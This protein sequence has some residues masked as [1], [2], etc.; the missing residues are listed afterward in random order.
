MLLMSALIGTASSARAQ[1]PIKADSGKFILL[2]QEAEFGTDVFTSDADG[3]SE[4]EIAITQGG[5]NLKVHIS[6]TVQGGKLTRV[7][8]E[9]RPGGKMDLTVEGEKGKL[10]VGEI[11]ANN[12]PRSGTARW[13]A[14]SC[15]SATGRSPRRPGPALRPAGRRCAGTRR[16]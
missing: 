9:A 16:P 6:V 7:V 15:T 10:A 5:V 13:P 8:A 12:P 4:S 11:G 1:Q 3:G 14:R 2:L